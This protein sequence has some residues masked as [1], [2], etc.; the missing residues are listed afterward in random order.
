MKKSSLFLDKKTLHTIYL[1]KY[2]Q[3]V[4]QYYCLITVHI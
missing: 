1:L 3:K 2:G 4:V